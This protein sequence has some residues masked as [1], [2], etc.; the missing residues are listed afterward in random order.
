AVHVHVGDGYLSDGLDVFAE[1]M[2]RVADMT[3]TLQEAGAP[4]AEVNTGGGLGV[5]VRTGDEPLDLARW[6]SIAAEHLGPLDV[7]GGSEKVTSWRS[8]TSAAT[9]RAC[10]PRTVSV[11]RPAPSSSRTAREPGPPRRPSM[12]PRRG[13]GRRRQPSLRD[14]RRSVPRV[15]RLARPRLGAG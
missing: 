7:R 9:T 10:T 11:R 14:A 8:S 3:A 2:G 5:P 15:Q 6:A 12:V 4:V 1:T 13:R